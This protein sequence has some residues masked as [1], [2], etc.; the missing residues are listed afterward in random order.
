MKKFFLIPLI[1]LFFSTIINFDAIAEYPKII[2]FQGLLT[3]EF[4]NPFPDAEYNVQFTI[5]DHE[6]NGAPVWTE[7]HLITTYKG[8]FDVL[9]GTVTPI[10]I[11]FDKSYWLSVVYENTEY[12]NPR[13][14]FTTVPYSFWA[15]TANI[16][17]G[18]SQDATGAV[19]NIN[20]L[21]GRINIIGDS[22]IF[23]SNNGNDINLSFSGTSIDTLS[24]LDGTMEIQ[25]PYG[26]NT[27]IGI[28]DG[29][30]TIDK[31]DPNIQLPLVGPAGGDLS[32]SYPN[33][34]LGSM[35]ASPGNV[36]KWNGTDW[37]PSPDELSTLNTTSPIMG[38]GTPAN[39]ISLTNTTVI[40]GLYGST[41]ESATFTV[42]AQG[43]LTKA[44]NVTISGT[45]PGGLAGG[46]LTGTYP[47]PTIAQKGAVNGQI[48]KWNGTAWVAQNDDGL[49]SVTVADPIIGDG[50]ALNPVGLANTLVTPGYYG[51]ATQV[52]SFNVD[53][54]GRLTT[55][56]N[57]TISGTL[58]GGSAGG[59]L[60]GTYPN[61]TIAQKGATNGQFLTWNGT[62]WVAT[63]PASVE[64]RVRANAPITGNGTTASPLGLANTAVTAGSYGS[65]TQVPTYTVD[66]QGRLTAA[67]N[68]AITG[69]VPDGTTN[70]QILVWNGTDW[71]PADPTTIESSV[72][73]TAP[74]TGDGTTATPLGLANTTVTAGS[75]GSATQVPTYTVDA[76]GRLTTASNVTITGTTPGGTAGG[77]LTGTYPNPTIAQKGATTGNVLNWN[78]SAWVPIDPSAMN[79][80]VNV[81]TPIT[82]DGTTA[83]PLGLANTTVTAGSY[84]SATQVP[85]YTVDA[86]GRLTAA[87]NV[88]I[89]GTV[90]DGTT[91]DQILVWNGSDW[92]PAD[93]A[94]TESSVEVTARLTG[95]GTTANPLDIAQN[96]ATNGNVLNWNGSAWVPIDPSAMNTSVNVT[97]PITGDGTSATPLGLANTAVAAGSYG[98]A[99]Q[100]PTYTVDAQGR[101]TAASNVTITGTVPNGTA[102]DQVLEWNGSAW[103]PVDPS[104]IETAVIVTA[105]I[106]GDGTT[107]NPLGLANTTVTPNSYGSATQVGTFTVDAQGRL[108]AAGNTTITGTTP[109]GTAGGDLTGTYPNPTI[110]SKGATAGQ[111]L[112]WDGDSWEPVD[113][114]TVES[115]V[116]T[117]A[118]ITG[119]GT[120]GN[121]LGL[122][123]TTVTPNS[124]GSATQVGTFTVDAQ[125]RLT[126]AGNT[127]I[128]GTVP[129]GTA[130][131][132]LTGTYPNPT[133]A[134]KGA[135]NGQVLKWNGS[136]WIPSTDNGTTYSAG[137][138]INITGTTITNTGDTDASNDI[139][140]STS[141]GGDLAGTYPNPTIAQKSATSGQVLKWNGSSWTPQTDNGLTTV[142]VSTPLTGDGTG[143]NP[144]GLAN[145]TVSAGSY[146]NATQVGTF[147]VDAQGRIT[148]AGNTTITGTVPG[149]TAGG[150]LTGTYPNPTLVSTAV[151]AGSYGSATQVGT[152]TVDSKGRLTAAGN[153]TISGTTPGGS[154]G[155]DLTGTYPNPT[156]A[157]KGASTNQVLTW[158]GTVWTPLDATN[159]AWGKTGNAGTSTS[160]NFIGTTDAVGLVFKTSNTERMRISSSGSIGIGTTTPTQ[161]LQ[162]NG[163]VLISGT[164]NKMMIADSSGSYSSSFK[165]RTQTANIN[166]NLPA[167][168]GNASS[169]LVNDGNGNLTWTEQISSRFTNAGVPQND[170]AKVA[171]ATM[172]IDVQNTSINLYSDGNLGRQEVILSNGMSVGQIL[173]LIVM[174]GTQ[175]Y[176]TRYRVSRSSTVKL[177]SPSYTLEKFDTM[178]MVWTGSFWLQTA[179]TINNG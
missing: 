141:A 172:N 165:S 26:P 132:D 37:V 23:V 17:H 51:S 3:D 69:T 64:S 103:V 84:G 53:Q 162:V 134:Q 148:A 73:V 43:R 131:G 171:D 20:G 5:F 146:G 79:T 157:S 21:T 98:S 156:L 4:N 75:Y 102:F 166:Y 144:I 126:A 109:G 85:T 22:K 61:P 147:T 151:T 105:P 58:P 154:A 42:D 15:D 174:S 82:G 153:T 175:G 93:P 143:G 178:I 40:P 168:Q 34:Q 113:P 65:A 91:A 66:A 9:L 38:D 179:V 47:N 94:T 19:L 142:S 106:T 63:D 72:S 92:V 71:V 176:T 97:A 116:S 49:I 10:D 74:I 87:S 70:D 8:V 125:G 86:Q 124:Y 57:I 110:A 59:D 127:T 28:R 107:G 90:P 52:P 46:D 77:D 30:I 121:P 122:A 108:T 48:L 137:T 36:L 76:Q 1:I 7:T 150:D 145:T 25:N 13:I 39:P 68:V 31:L 120:T 95:D 83:T 111:F 6:T 33:P 32:G 128:T 14:P 173:Y 56:S 100:V 159:S 115:S 78:G 164:G 117:D 169:Y 114:T 158:N 139:T 99:T 177:N 67:A 119:D 155:G 149:G 81:T 96:G 161:T 80:S 29:S 104:T 54:K 60:T 2:S 41:T 129:G 45:R 88:T 118:P 138:G 12:L 27:S 101:L 62:S 16:A 163:N 123:N 130:G 140:T 136:A 50:T 24:P 133:I 35:G 55:A 11:P 44:G 89:T 112:T 160:T 18:L 167:S 135:T 152:F 170:T